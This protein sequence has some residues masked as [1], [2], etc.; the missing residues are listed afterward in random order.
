MNNKREQKKANM[1]KAAVIACFFLLFAV[2]LYFIARWDGRAEPTD[3]ES[4]TSE[5]QVWEVDGVDYV[6]NRDIETVLVVGLDKYEFESEDG[7]YRNQN[8]AD[9]VLLL[10][11]DH[12]AKSYKAVQINRDTYTDVEV[13]T[14]NNKNYT[15]KMQLALSYT[16]G[17]GT[18]K[19]LNNTAKAVSKLLYG[20]E[21][22]K[23][24][25]VKLDA[26]P[27]VNDMVDGVTLTVLD[28]F[29]AF[30]ST[31]VKGAEVKLSGEQALLYVRARS[32]MEDSSNIRRMERQRQYL[33]ALYKK[34]VATAKS[35]EGFALEAITKVSEYL[36]SDCVNVELTELFDKLTSY[37]FKGIVSVEGESKSGEQFM[38]FYPDAAKLRSLVLETFFVQQ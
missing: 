37:E 35:D 28:D 8:C 31:L 4:T 5:A 25:S 6:Q 30:D 12:N 13:I 32:G 18:L 36:V 20:V 24:I 7:G 2:A 34:T 29:T 19:S 17:S 10:A 21:I 14:I 33:D 16:Y 1:K 26:V 22:D 27:V 9:F 3:T 15:E 38:E 23:R 11:V